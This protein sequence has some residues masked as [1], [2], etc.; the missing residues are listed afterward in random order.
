VAADSKTLSSYDLSSS[1]SELE[2]FQGAGKFKAGV[3]AVSPYSLKYGYLIIISLIAIFIL[4]LILSISPIS[5]IVPFFPMQ[6][7]AIHKMRH[8]LVE[9]PEDSEGS[10]PRYC[11]LILFLLPIVF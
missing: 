1:L 7:L 3:N 10:V 11:L 6:V 5:P 9:S 2:L 8:L 4:S